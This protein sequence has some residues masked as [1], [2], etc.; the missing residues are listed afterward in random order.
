MISRSQRLT[1]TVRCNRH[2]DDDGTSRRV[3][4]S[5]A[6]LAPGHGNHVRTPDRLSTALGPIQ[7][8]KRRQIRSQ[9]SCVS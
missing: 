6:R 9:E 1:A 3:W 2:Q 4:C 8:N 5:P 7:R